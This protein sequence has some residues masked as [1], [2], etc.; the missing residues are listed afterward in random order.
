VKSPQVN[1][2][3]DQSAPRVS[4]FRRLITVALTLGIVISTFYVLSIGEQF[5]VPL[6][7]AVLAVYLVDILSRFIRNI[8]VAS[9]SLPGIVSLILAFGIIFGLGFALIEIIAQNALHVA[10][11]AP[12]YQARLQQ[13]QAEL[14]SRVGIEEP[15]EL[16]QLVKTIDL[17]SVFTAVAK[18]VAALL[19]NVTLVVIY[20]LFIVLE[21]RFVPIKVQALFPDP[22]RRKNAIRIIRRIDRDIHTYLGV[23]TAVSF[24]SALLAYILMRIVGLDFAEF[25]A[26]L[27]FVLHFIPTFGVIV[28]TLLPTL[29]AAVQFEN[30]GP[31]LIIGIGITAIAQLMG[32]IVEPNVM[33]ETLNLSPLTVIISLIVWGSV[34]GIV[35]AFLCVPLTV[36]L[37]IVLSNFEST[38]W[39]SILLSKTGEIR[40]P[41]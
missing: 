22:E 39:V 2:R 17:R 27:V 32:N 38:R 31:F 20:G 6:V 28:A 35:G 3:I 25:W 29:L 36:I 7:M 16:R 4:S 33:G 14:F 12:K 18:Q 8:R 21:Q 15:P 23:K 41:I 13:L 30:L 37:V 10:A 34:W 19:E 11:A 5:F 9:H 24:T 40:A 1:S 26:L